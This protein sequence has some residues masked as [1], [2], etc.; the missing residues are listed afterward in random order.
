MAID[1]STAAIA[2][3]E[4]SRDAQSLKD[5]SFICSTVGSAGF[6]DALRQA[7][8]H[9]D[10]A[11]MA[12]ARF[13]LHAITDNE[14]L[15]FFKDMSAALHEGD[16]GVLV[17]Q[18]V[19]AAQAG[20]PGVAGNA[21]ASTPLELTAAPPGVA[22][23]ASIVTMTGGVDEETDGELLARLLELIRRPPAGGNRADYRRWALETP[24]VSAAYVYPLRR[25]RGTGDVVVTA[26]GDRPSGATLAAVQAH[27]D[28]LRPVTAKNC[29]VLAP[30]PRV[31]D[32]SVAVRLSGLTLAQA[33]A[34][35]STALSEYF[36]RLAPGDTAVRSRMEALVSD[37]TG[38]ADRNLEQ[39]AAN[40][41]PQVDDRVVEWAR[42]GTVTVKVMA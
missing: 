24:G 35:I 15:A 30:T 31:L 32:V 36:A 18:A 37:I 19:V 23:Q 42:L 27:I 29:L 6:G 39:P 34:Q 41:V 8:A 13:F 12:Y 26:A 10:G 2:K 14:E 5:I 28:E 20:I 11:A 17:G 38:V 7:R 22:S 4:E 1:G 16:P 40:F 25:G 33:Q 9:S 3:C 21:D